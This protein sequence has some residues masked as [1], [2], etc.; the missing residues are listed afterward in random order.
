MVSKVTMASGQ[1]TM[2]AATKVT[3]CLPKDW[4]SPSFTSMSSWLST[5][6][7]NCRMSMKDFSV[8]MTFTSGQRMRISSMEAPW[9][10]SMWLMT[11]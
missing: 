6:K 10:G 9:S 8:E 11:R 2:G 1:W 3:T 5:W 4:V 7:P